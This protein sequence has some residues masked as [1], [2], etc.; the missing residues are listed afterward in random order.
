MKVEVGDD[1]DDIIIKGIRDY[2]FYSNSV[3]G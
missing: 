2:P 3:S 1:I